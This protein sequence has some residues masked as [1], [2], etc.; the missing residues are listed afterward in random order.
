MRNVTKA[1]RELAPAQGYVMNMTPAREDGKARLACEL[2]FGKDKVDKVT[3]TLHRSRLNYDSLIEDFLE[4]DRD[5]VRRFEDPDTK[6]I[7]NTV[8]QSIIDDLGDQRI[9]PLTF[10][11]VRNLSDFPGAKSPGLPYKNQG[12]RSKAE[13]YD[14]KEN[15]EHLENIWDLIGNG[16]NVYLPDVCLFARS[17]IAKYPKEKIRATWGYSFD[18]YMEEARFFYPIQEFIKSHKHK[19]PIAYGLE[20]AHG[21]MNSINDMLLRNRGCKYVISDWSKFD[22]TI[23]PWLIRDAFH[24]LEKL[25][26]FESL[27]RPAYQ[28]RRFKKIVDYFVE[29][30]IRTCKGE[31]FLVTGGVPSGSCF[32][33][34]IDSII[35]CIVTRF[36][37]YQTTN[38][39]PIGEIFLG[40]DGVFVISGFACLEDIASLAIKYFGMILNVDKS[41]VTTNP[42]N[43]HFLGYFNY[44]GMPFKNQ[45]FLIASFIFPE[46]KRTRLI[47]ACAAAL[48]QMYSGFDPGYA[49]TWLKIIHYLA[50]AEN[51][52]PFNFHEIVLHLRNNEFR[53]KYL[54]QVGLTSDNMTI[55]E[56][57]SSM[58]LEVL[59]KSYCAISLPNRTYDYKSLYIRSLSSFP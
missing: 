28:R 53:H 50:D 26:D 2:F 57:H 22:K 55:P 41:Y 34:I 29:T 3:N 48:G 13:V 52:N 30:P 15:L 46:H 18:V 7:Y 32:T 40:D 21:G 56:L 24:I 39:F 47:D 44:S 19:L 5:H 27:P 36:L 31:R 45:D 58:I 43:V 33:N 51:A 17:Q 1:I 25:I 16:K 54:A 37:V 4:Y 12:Y 8:L 9:K 14:C 20:M 49:R 23:P 35:N 10:D 59:P 6:L 42:Q 11:Q 38:Q